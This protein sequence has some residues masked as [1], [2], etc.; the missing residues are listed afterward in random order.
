MRLK[1]HTAL[2]TGSGRGLGKAI[3]LR[4]AQE[5]ANVITN[6]RSTP[7][8]CE[9]LAEQCR[10][11][12]VRS[13]GVTADLSSRE[14][15]DALAHKALQE[16]GRVDILVNNL[17]I[18]PYLG[19]LE[20]S[21]E[22]WHKILFVDLHQMFFCTRHFTPGMLEQRWGR[23]LFITGHAAKR[24]HKVGAHTCAAKAGAMGLMRAVA[25][26]FAGAGITSNEICPGWMDTEIR[27]NQYYDDHKPPNQRP[28]GSDERVKE[29]PAGRLGTPEEFGALCA[30]LASD[31]GSYL[32]GQTYLINGGTVFH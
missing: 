14:G 4:F 2:I 25:T 1:G 20:I 26:E 17:G 30:F 10:A 9:A 13:M 24:R 7:D 22:E 28:W 11:Y 5:G 23:I 27:R 16:F 18:S 21:D 31:E 15:V 3:A 12:G 32:T 29:I 6:S 8:E 19:L